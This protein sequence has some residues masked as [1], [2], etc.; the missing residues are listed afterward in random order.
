[1]RYKKDHPT[2]QIIADDLLCFPISRKFPISVSIVNIIKHGLVAC[3]NR[4]VYASLLKKGSRVS[5]QTV[6]GTVLQVNCGKNISPNLKYQRVLMK[7][8]QIETQMR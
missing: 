2:E 5:G 1:M 7:S 4:E 8:L 3:H 6:V